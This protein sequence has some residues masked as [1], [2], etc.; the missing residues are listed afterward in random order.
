MSAVVGGLIRHGLTTLGGGLVANGFAS[1]SEMQAL[2]GALITVVGIG[3]SIT[4]KYLAKRN[5]Q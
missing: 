4:Q 2:I 3:F 5:A 1:D